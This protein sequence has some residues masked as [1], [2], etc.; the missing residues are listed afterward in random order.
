MKNLGEFEA[1]VREALASHASSEP[2]E[3]LY[4][5]T[6][7]DG[8][9]KIIE[10]DRLLASD[11][12]FMNDSLEHQ[13]AWRLVQQLC[14]AEKE[15]PHH[16]IT[17]G[18]IKLVERLPGTHLSFSGGAFVA[19]FSDQGDLLSQWRAYGDDGSGVALGFST[20]TTLGAS[21]QPLGF[22]RVLYDRGEQLSALNKQVIAIL[23]LAD[24]VAA[25]DGTVTDR[26]LSALQ[27]LAALL[28]P[29]IKNPAFS[30]ERE[31]RLVLSYL[32][33]LAPLRLTK[34]RRGRTGL[35]PYCE[36]KTVEH[37]VR[38]SLPI[39]EIIVGPR[40]EGLQLDA[41]ITYLATQGYMAMMPGLLIRPELDPARNVLLKRSVASYR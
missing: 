21:E 33:A 8:A 17:K 28:G 12:R 14:V 11:I 2:P 7:L 6:S 27:I 22:N 35:V 16:E 32:G 9:M 18:L 39:R 30:E 29:T 20:S 23:D 15:K 34:V 41:F 1:L 10:S 19:S 31:W 13:F 26:A 36:L 38:P 24:R 3:I 5:Y 25:N 37:S 40:F 4:H